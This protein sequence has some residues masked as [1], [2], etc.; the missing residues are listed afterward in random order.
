VRRRDFL[1][2]QAATA[3]GLVVPFVQPQVAPLEGRQIGTVPIG[4]LDRRPPPFD[5]LLGAGLNAR[6]FTDLS[7]LT[8]TSPVTPNGR[9]FIRTSCPPALPARDDWWI[10]VGGLVREPR[11]IR[12]A[13]L[14]NLVRPVGTH[15]LE[16]SGNADPTNFGLMSEARWE[17]VP[18]ASF[19]DRLGSLARAHRVL[20]SGADYEDPTPTS[21][22]G[23]S[24]IFR[25]EELESAG[26]FLALRMN[27]VALP[28]D[29]GFPIRLVVPG[30]YGA[31]CIKWVN[32]IDFVDDDAPTTSQMREF[33]ARTHQNG[34]PAV[35][36]DYA[37][38]EIDHA[39]LPVRV[40]KWLTRDRLVYRIVGI[41]WGG[42]R[43]T[44]RLVIRLGENMPFVP[45]SDCPLQASTSQWTV[46]THLWRPEA[47]GMYRVALRID[48]PSLRTR[49]LDRAFYAREVQI[50]EV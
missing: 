1:A 3:V 21:L 49:R 18:L 41:L 33:A 15:V 19:L 40:E 11:T 20:V 12:L 45:V 7:T 22:P 5:R 39:A 25:R 2:V 47:P 9:F 10:R 27:G 17:G 36:R 43:P 23:A 4:R 48:D 26:A 50:E 24:W 38:A 34:V 8:S 42:S 35:A 46:W 6:L 16:C 29:H 14:S 32:Q 31:A 37:P 28:R 44:N 13:S 30:W